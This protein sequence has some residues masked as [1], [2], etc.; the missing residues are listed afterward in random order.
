MSS[1][2]LA[3]SDQVSG[4]MKHIKNGIGMGSCPSTGAGSVFFL[5]FGV[6]VDS[7]MLRRGAPKSIVLNICPYCVTLLAGHILRSVPM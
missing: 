2:G 5:P 6:S 3:S 1:N 7:T 4:S